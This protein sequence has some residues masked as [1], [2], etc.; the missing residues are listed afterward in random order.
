MFTSNICSYR[1][2]ATAYV[3]TVIVSRLILSLLLPVGYT[4]FGKLLIVML[5]DFIVIF[6]CRNDGDGE[7]ID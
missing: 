5:V 6:S 2:V 3:A 7:C 4:T 1:Y